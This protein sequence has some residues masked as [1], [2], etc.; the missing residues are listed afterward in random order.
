LAILRGN[1]YWID[2]GPRRG[3]EPAFVHPGLVISI[4]EINRLP[5]VVTVVP[6]TSA[7]P[8]QRDFPR[9]QV[10]VPAAD[11]GLPQDTIFKCFQTTVVDP[12]KVG[13]VVGPLS[14]QYLSEVERTVMRLLG[15][16]PL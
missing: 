3:R 10:R 13:D 6:G 1:I 16:T 14:P 2:F 15:L 4:D 11:S 8:G 7:K 5:L 12:D 9:T